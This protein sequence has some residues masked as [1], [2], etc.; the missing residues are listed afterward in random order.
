MLNTE[1][2][3]LAIQ[4]SRLCGPMQEAQ[5]WFLVTELRSHVLLEMAKKIKI[6]IQLP[7]V[8]FSSVAQSC[9]THCHPIDCSTPG[10]S[11]LRT[12]QQI[13][14][15]KIQTKILTC[16]VWTNLS[17]TVS[18]IYLLTLI[19]FRYSSKPAKHPPASKALDFLSCFYFLTF[20]S[21]GWQKWWFSILV[22]F[23]N[24]LDFSV[25]RK[26]PSSTIWLY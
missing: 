2:T 3:S 17:P 23:L 9:P 1:W 7:S 6:N 10:F 11:V 20:S 8:Q 19:S 24:L 15:S 22:F 18:L 25:K 16:K 4:W 26:F 5:V 21:S 14:N 13:Y 12:L